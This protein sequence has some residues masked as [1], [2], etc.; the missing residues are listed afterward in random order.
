M[1]NF[2]EFCEITSMNVDDITAE[3]ADI[4]LDEHSSQKKELNKVLLKS[5]VKR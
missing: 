5:P 2:N 1:I 3:D 4:A